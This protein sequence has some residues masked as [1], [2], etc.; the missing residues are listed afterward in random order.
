MRVFSWAMMKA[1]ARCREA[2]PSVWSK[3]QWVLMSSVRL[4]GVELAERLKQLRR[5]GGDLR[6]DDQLAVG[7]DLADDITADALEQKN[8]IGEFGGPDGLVGRGGA[9]LLG[10]A[11]IGLDGGIRIR[12]RYV[13]AGG[14]RAA[15]QAAGAA[16]GFWAGTF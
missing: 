15:R 4:A 7:T 3:C 6:I 5:A 16:C 9:Q 1:P 2:L 10:E 11:G 12:R 14:Q 13:L 8:C